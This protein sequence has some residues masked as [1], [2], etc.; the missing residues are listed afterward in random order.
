MQVF[1]IFEPKLLLD[2]PRVQQLMNPLNSGALN[3]RKCWLILQRYLVIQFESS[4]SQWKIPTQIMEIL[5]IWKFPDT[6]KKHPLSE[7][8]FVK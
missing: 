6:F 4:S 7:T 3:I 8:Q 1:P 5:G 2:V